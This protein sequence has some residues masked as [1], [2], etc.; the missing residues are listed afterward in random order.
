M[1]R[2]WSNFQWNIFNTV[3]FEYTWFGGRRC[4]CCRRCR[5]RCRCRRCRRRLYCLCCCCRCRC[6]SLHDPNFMAKVKIE[7]EIFVHSLYAMVQLISKH[8]QK[9]NRSNYM[10]YFLVFKNC[11]FWCFWVSLKKYVHLPID[12]MQWKWN[13]NWI[14]S[15][16]NMNASILFCC[17]V[18]FHRSIQLIPYTLLTT[19]YKYIQTYGNLRR[20]K[21]SKNW[22]KS[23]VKVTMHLTMIFV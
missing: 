1:S 10:I 12:W 3:H 2:P 17:C 9:W 4:R 18:Y 8:G 21:P 5:C 23:K 22:M 15:L 19:H 13:Q 6:L 16:Y 11:V 7:S 20:W 14:W